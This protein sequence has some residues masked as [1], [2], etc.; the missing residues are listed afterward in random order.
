MYEHILEPQS[1]RVQLSRRDVQQ[2][3]PK[4]Q[5]MHLVEVSHEKSRPKGLGQLWLNQI[6]GTQHLLG[7]VKAGSGLCIIKWFQFRLANM[8]SWESYQ[9][10]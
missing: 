7:S 8:N 3:N 5:D 2:R 1:L 10:L 4:L 6:S 9:A